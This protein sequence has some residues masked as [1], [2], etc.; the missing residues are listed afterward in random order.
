MAIFSSKRSLVLIGLLSIIF[1]SCESNQNDSEV[2]VVSAD[3]GEKLYLQNCVQCH[4]KNGNLG[5]SGASDLST[6]AKSLEEKILFIQQGSANGIMPAYGKEFGG[7]YS[8][9]DI[10]KIA[11]YIENMGH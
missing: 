9:E 2:H 11:S 10:K 7:Q 1:N 4:G 8:E 6:S 5:V 3:S